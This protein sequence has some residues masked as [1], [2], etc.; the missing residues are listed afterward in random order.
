MTTEEIAARDAADAAE[1][2]E[3]EAQAMLPSQFPTGVAITNSE[4]HWVEFIPDGTNK[5]ANTLAVQ[6]SNSPL[7]KEER[8]SM[9]DA[10]LAEYN[11]K[12][13]VAKKAKAKGNGLSAVADRVA[14][15]E[16]LHGIE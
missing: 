7:T 5:V 10:A 15:L 4:G 3:A 6:I 13:E 14:A 9:R 11:A 8:E 1:Q 16:A 12:K 2:A